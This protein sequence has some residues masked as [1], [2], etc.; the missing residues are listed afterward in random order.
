MPWLI[1]ASLYIFTM[2]VITHKLFNNIPLESLS[3]IVPLSVVAGAFA[4]MSYMV[5]KSRLDLERM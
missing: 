4:Q 5:E 2:C 3:I 1:T